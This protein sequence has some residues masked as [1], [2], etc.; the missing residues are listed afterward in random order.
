[1]ADIRN[2]DNFIAS[3]WSY[4]YFD[5]AFRPTRISFGDL[6]AVVERNGQFLVLET[7]GEGVPVPTGQEM[8]FN[9][10]IDC[11]NYT[12]LI[13]WGK[14]PC[15][16]TAWRIWPGLKVPVDKATVREFILEWRRMAERTP[17]RKVQQNIWFTSRSW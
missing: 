9:R 10:M 16:V 8:M 11:G 15:E 17:P 5:E 2:M 1:M 13:L 6:D 14:P 4:G 12:V 3:K 7:K